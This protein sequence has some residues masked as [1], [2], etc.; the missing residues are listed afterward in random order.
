MKVDKLVGKKRNGIL[1][2]YS[3]G[4]QKLDLAKHPIHQNSTRDA[5]NSLRGFAILIVLV[6]HFLNQYV[7]S[8]EFL[9]FANATISIFF[10]LSGYGIAHSLEQ[11]PE[12]TVMEMRPPLLFYA[13]RILRI[14]PLFIISL[15]LSSWILN[16]HFPIR[17]YLGIK[18]PGHYRFVNQIIEC[19]LVA[20][21]LYSFLLRTS[22]K[23]FLLSAV[24]LFM[25][26]NILLLLTPLGKLDFA[27]YLLRS[28]LG[29]RN[30]ILSHLLLFSLGMVIYKFQ[31]GKDL[32]VSS[33]A[34]LF[35]AILALLL[36]PAL[37]LLSKTSRGS[38]SHIGIDVLFFLCSI[39]VCQLFIKYRL[40]IRY[41]S[42]LGI[43]SYSLYLFHM[44]YYTLLERLHILQRNSM[45][46]IL[47]A[48]LL[49]PLFLFGCKTM[50]Q[51]VNRLS[52]VGSQKLL[53]LRVSKDF[54]GRT[55]QP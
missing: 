40:N 45:E 15:L 54:E 19:Y 50:E 25:I 34:V 38:L 41:L 13:D 49:F 17:A 26:L 37:F 39:Y 51:V 36:L 32:L 47:G 55:D 43:Y 53:S 20:P 16:D 11:R 14:Y 44:T 33:R 24:S 8:G 18:S 7:G 22:I 23:R 1:K 46:G 12:H 3:F 52:R 48:V 6:N 5:T 28:P 31:Q 21:L 9:G 30:L 4:N 42:Y 2:T 10:V 29:Y 27:I 35:K